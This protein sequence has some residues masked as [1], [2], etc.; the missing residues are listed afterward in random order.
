MVKHDKSWVNHG[1]FPNSPRFSRWNAP[2]PGVTSELGWD[3]PILRTPAAPSPKPAA[4]P[5]PHPAWRPAGGCRGNS[6]TFDQ[7]MVDS[8][9]KMVDLMGFVGFY[10]STKG[11]NATGKPWMIGFFPADV[12]FNQVWDDHKSWW[13]WWHVIL[14][15]IIVIFSM[16]YSDDHHSLSSTKI[17]I[18][19]C[20]MAK[21]GPTAVL[22]KATWPII[23]STA[24]WQMLPTYSWVCPM[25]KKWLYWEMNGYSNQIMGDGWF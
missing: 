12:R 4:A 25:N 21:K 5:R 8:P 23:S 15:L 14:I 18:R 6:N 10:G 3:L 16:L 19:P 7:Q 13:S 9:W 17:K 1:E 2:L 11:K 22:S 24:T 20:A